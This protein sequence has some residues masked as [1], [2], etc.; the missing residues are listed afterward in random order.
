MNG[1]VGAFAARHAGV[2]SRSESD[3]ATIRYHPMAG[4]I[5]TSKDWDPA[6]NARI[7]SSDLVHVSNF[8]LC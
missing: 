2:A 1:R 8:S 6:R 3:R 4:K 5:A 7:A